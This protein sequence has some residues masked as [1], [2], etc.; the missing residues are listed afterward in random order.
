MKRKLLDQLD[1]KVSF[2]L[3]PSLVDAEAGRSR[4]SSG[5]RKTP[6]SKATT[7]PRSSRPTSIASWP[8]AG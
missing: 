6:R 2:D 5:T 8:S 4:T 7:T 3:P 1:E